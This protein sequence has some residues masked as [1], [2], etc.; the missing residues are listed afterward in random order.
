MKTNNHQ[1]TNDMHDLRVLLVGV[2]PLP[3]GGI[4]IHLKRVQAKLE[5]QGC[6]VLAWDVC[7][8]QVGLGQLR[9]YWQLWLFCIKNQPQVI[10][11]HT[12]QLRS[13]PIELFLLLVAGKWLKSKNLA[14]MHSSR[15]IYR[16]SWLSRVLTSLVLKSYDQVIL[17]SNALKLE[18]STKIKL[19]S[20]IAIESPFLLP[21]FSTGPAILNNL[22]DNLKIFLISHKPIISCAVTRHALW[23]GADLYGTDLALASF[24]LLKKDY[25]SAGLVLIIGHSAGYE[26]LGKISGVYT[27]LDWPDEIWPIIGK[28]DLFI[29]PNRSDSFGISIL[30]AICLGV[31]V[32]ASNV[33]VRPEQVVL[34]KSGNIHDLY[35]K[36]IQVLAP[37]NYELLTNV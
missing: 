25:P 23:Q 14:M 33:C 11:Y 15:F 16:L 24:E 28:S 30:E 8:R 2:F 9:Y 3:L 34:F 12:M 31:P 37:K 18:I 1:Y 13:Y 26:S 36:K 17:V 4:S 27:L 35:L 32:V 29:R 20:N 7:K 6:T 22:P 19:S 21:D 10:I 5:A